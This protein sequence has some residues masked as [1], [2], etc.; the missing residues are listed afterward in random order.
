MTT[1]LNFTQFNQ[2][3]HLKLTEPQYTK[4]QD[5]QKLNLDEN[6]IL[7]LIKNPFLRERRLNKAHSF[8]SIDFQQELLSPFLKKNFKLSERNI[9]KIRNILTSLNKENDNPY[10]IEKRAAVYKIIQNPSGRS[11]RINKLW[12][13][14]LANKVDYLNTLPSNPT[15]PCSAR[16]RPLFADKIIKAL[17]SFAMKLPSFH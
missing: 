12:K 5:L 3:H 2:N 8:F 15:P 16:E 4:V 17:A 6:V 1:T 7:R 14:T 13:E 10:S 9:G 11:Q